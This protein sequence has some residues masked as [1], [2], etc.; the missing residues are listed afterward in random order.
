[1]E[2]MINPTH[3][4]Q[5]L[6]DI[7]SMRSHLA[8]GQ[9]NE[10]Y[11]PGRFWDSLS[12]KHIGWINA[13]GFENFKRTINFEYSQ[14]G[15]SSF[16]DKKLSR[17]L[18]LLL[19]QGL[20]PSNIFKLKMDENMWNSTHWSDSIDADTGKTLQK[21]VPASMRR[22]HWAYSIYLALLWQYAASQDRLDI[23]TSIEEPELGAPL[24]VS[25]RGK[26]ISQ[27]LALSALE[28][29]HMAE[30]IPFT[31]NER[32]AEIGAGYGRLAYVFLKKFPHLKYS[33]FDIPPALAV[34]KNYLLQLFGQDKVIPCWLASPSASLASTAA[35]KFY[36]PFQLEEFP[37]NYFD[38]VVN[39]SSFDEM[40]AGQI[41]KYFE[42]IHQKCR[43]WLYVKG[44]ANM[45]SANRLG[46]DNFPYN[47]AWSLVWKSADP[48]VGS[49]EERIYR[50]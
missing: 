18:V 48:V 24:P 45:R 15:V 32:V 5:V 36:L 20:F 40:S 9:A 14:W 46:L 37:D 39:V 12:E 35:A 27:D 26:R 29:N 43:G 42:L 49:F 13:Y 19:R 47:P 17:L 8:Q 28:I 31:K 4:T 1:M 10:L 34:C 11:G 50:L 23:L 22:T 38:V 3:N 33:V 6:N 16:S 21:N 41:R 2:T 30:H 44:H 7:A 25:L